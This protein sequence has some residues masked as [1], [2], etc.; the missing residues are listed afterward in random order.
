MLA[1]WWLVPFKDLLQAALWLLAFT[2][3]H[4]ERRA[5]RFRQRRDGKI[6]KD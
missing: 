6:I 2:G 5:E 3:N 1:F 4:I